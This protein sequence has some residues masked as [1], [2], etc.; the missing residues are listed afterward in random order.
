MRLEAVSILKRS[1][2]SKRKKMKRSPI[3]GLEDLNIHPEEGEWV[4]MQSDYEWD[5][6]CSDDKEEQLRGLCLSESV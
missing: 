2:Q 6:N 4:E 3:E 5:N 1:N